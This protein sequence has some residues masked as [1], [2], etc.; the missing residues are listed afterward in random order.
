MEQ[1]RDHRRIAQPHR[2]GQRG[3]VVAGRFL[4]KVDTARQ[5]AIAQQVR[6]AIVEGAALDA[7]MK[8]RVHGIV[9]VVVGITAK[10]SEE[11]LD[12]RV[13]AQARQ[14]EHHGGH[15][16]PKKCVIYYVGY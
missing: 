3:L 1:A 11:A 14:R 2:V 9:P 10:A 8:R 15:A 16:L 7:Q 13:H 6:A 4:V 5:Q 12:A